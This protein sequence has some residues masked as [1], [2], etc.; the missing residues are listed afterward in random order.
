MKLHRAKTSRKLMF[1]YTTS[2]AFRPPYQ[3]LLTSS[4][5][6]AAASCRMNLGHLLQ[7][8]LQSEIKP[9]ITQCCIRHLYDI[10]VADGDTEARAQ[11]EG[12][13]AV[14]K[15]A[16]R[17]RCGHHELDEPLAEMECILSVLDP[18]NSGTNR[19]KYIVCTQDRAFR[20]RLRSIP[21]V[22]LVYI[23][24]SVMILEPMAEASETFREKEERGKMRAGLLGGR[25]VKRQR[26]D[27]EGDDRGMG[28]KDD[29]RMEE[30]VVK[31][32]KGP[33][34]PNPLSVKKSAK[35]VEKSGR[36]E[37]DGDGEDGV[38]VRKSAQKE[39]RNGH[40][41]DG[42]EAVQGDAGNVHDGERVKRKR[43]R[44]PKG[45]DMVDAPIVSTP[46]VVETST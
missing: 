2:F 21:G 20:S 33:K 22:P 31:R 5:I 37:K 3:V 36:G 30:R 35:V 46:A 15:E 23:N 11:K 42:A 1:A 16:E 19:H 45:N 44:K 24:R 10:E 41:V 26:D 29:G 9:M 43:R 13:I 38:A 12:V 32:K 28:E 4:F 25:G 34:A 7:N 8:T 17:R 18:K 40:S 27:G 39:A 6:L 14:A